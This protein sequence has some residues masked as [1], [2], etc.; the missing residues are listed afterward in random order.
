MVEQRLTPDGRHKLRDCWLAST[1]HC[2]SAEP[3]AGIAGGP[4]SV[5]V[6]EACEVALLEAGIEDGVD[7]GTCPAGPSGLEGALAELAELEQAALLA[8][9]PEV[10][11]G[12]VHRGLDLDDPEAFEF[13]E[14]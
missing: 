12:A 10:S 5:G 14:L 9:S 2:L 13:E 6:G 7:S 1:G 3:V 11:G 8:V 4:A